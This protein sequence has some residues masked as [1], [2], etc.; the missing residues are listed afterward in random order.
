MRGEG[1]RR[2]RTESSR[3]IQ[4][5]RAF[6]SSRVQK[7]CGHAGVSLFCTSGTSPVCPVSLV[8]LVDPVSLVQPNTQDKPNKLIKRDRPNRPHEQDR[9]ADFSASCWKNQRGRT[10]A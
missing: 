8:H 1:Y 4:Q 5:I 3:E 10:K 7:R 2:I 6:T 9:L